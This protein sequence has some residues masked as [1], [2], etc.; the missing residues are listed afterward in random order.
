MGRILVAYFMG[1]NLST[2]VNDTIII[3]EWLLLY[4]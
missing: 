2:N 1:D 3:R 4:V